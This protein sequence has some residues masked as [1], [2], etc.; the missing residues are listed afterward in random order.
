MRKKFTTSLEEDLIIELKKRAIDE[1][2]K[3]NLIIEKLLRDYLSLE[4]SMGM[5]CCCYECGKEVLK[6]VDNHFTSEDGRILCE[7]CSQGVEP[8]TERIKKI[9]KRLDEQ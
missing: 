2:T 4:G 5:K 7:K 3:P 9:L 1:R 8:C 6:G